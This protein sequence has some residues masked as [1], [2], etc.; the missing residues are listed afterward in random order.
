MEAKKYNQYYYNTVWKNVLSKYTTKSPVYDLGDI[1]RQKYVACFIHIFLKSCSGSCVKII[2]FG[3]GN[4]LYLGSI[5]QA[6]KEHNATNT[7]K[8]SFEI[9]GVDYCEQALDFG[10]EKFKDE[11]PDNVIIEKKNGEINE[12]AKN[13]SNNS[14]DLVIVLETLEHLYDDKGFIAK[15]CELLTDKGAI[16]IS[17]PN[18]KPFFLSKNWFVYTFFKKSFS[19]KDKHVGHLRRY[20]IKM[21]QN[22]VPQFDMQI[23]ETKFYGFFLSDYLKYI[24]AAMEKINKKFVYHIFKISRRLVLSENEFYNKIGVKHSEGFFV[25]LR[26]V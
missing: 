2:D 1:S 13:T 16:M 8:K 24:L 20:N 10:I 23:F 26:R 4:W 3:A 25:F 12:I 17:V 7:E 18:N 15:A 22:I 9:I 21:I 5:L 19:Q 6:I 11:I 14:C